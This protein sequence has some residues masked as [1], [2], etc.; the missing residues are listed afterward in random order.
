MR[1][2]ALLLLACACGQSSVAG[3]S[4]LEI[5][6]VS[7][8]TVSARGGDVVLVKGSGFGL[9]PRA[10]VR[11]EE[12][13]AELREDELLAITIPRTVAGPA[14]L[15]IASELAEKT[16]VDALEIRPISL[17]FVEAPEWLQPEL[18]G[19]LNGAQEVLFDRRKPPALLFGSTRGLH[20][21]QAGDDGTWSTTAFPLSPPESAEE[22]SIAAL[23]V[24]PSSHLVA[25]CT[26]DDA[27]I[28]LLAVESSSLRPLEAPVEA[29]LACEWITFLRTGFGR[30]VLLARTTS[31]VLAAW[32]HDGTRYVP[33]ELSGAPRGDV[34]RVL[35]LDGD[36]DDDL[37]AGGV[38]GEPFVARCFARLEESA[39]VFTRDDAYPA[40]QGRPRALVPL[41][42]NHDGAGD[43]FVAGDG[44]DALFLNDGHDRFF[45]DA[46]RRLPFERARGVDAVAA[47]L[48]LDGFEDLL[49]ATEDGPDR[50]FLGS[51]TGF[52]DRTPTLGLDGPFGSQRILAFDV[53]ADGDLDVLTARPGES[54]LRL[55][56]LVDAEAP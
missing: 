56:L 49:V 15:R 29:P 24:D 8:R 3:R 40:P 52:V 22:P 20:A 32:R 11:D 18:G 5:S 53:D 31:G 2:V 4:V 16:L 9:Q 25:A 47:D 33:L 42:V 46:W 51:P 50:L 45:D 48:D 21:L 43:L 36:G 27:A 6:D 54:T 44:R 39:L 7:P 26:S 17:A 55:R 1:R 34:L 35:D 30:E 28:R 19:G 23:A 41:D 12:V 13:V 14:D 37:L 10:W 38:D